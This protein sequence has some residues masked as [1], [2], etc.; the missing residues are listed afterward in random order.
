[1]VSAAPVQVN[2]CVRRLDYFLKQTLST[3]EIT[4]RPVQ[5]P[6]DQRA[7]RAALF[8]LLSGTKDYAVEFFMRLTT[9][10]NDSIQSIQVKSGAP[11]IV[12]KLGTA[13]YCSQPLT[14]RPIAGGNGKGHFG[15]S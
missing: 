2:L 7:H 3:G 5:L 14:A 6:T 4:L 13:F 10:L 1:M 11:C 9:G 15:C 12:C 8:L